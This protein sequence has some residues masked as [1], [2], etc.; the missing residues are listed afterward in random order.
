MGCLLAVVALAFPRVVLALVFLFSDFLGR[1][2]ET[3]LWPVLGFFF[4]PF[5]TL[6]YAA[7]MNWND[8]TVSGLYLVMVVIAVLMDLGSIGG[9]GHRARRRGQ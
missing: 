5:T 7:A 8:G 3:T 4:M 9:G 2:Y 6:A 1:A